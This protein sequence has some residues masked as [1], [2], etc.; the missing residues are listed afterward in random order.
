MKHK[1]LV[2]LDVT[3]REKTLKDAKQELMR[4]RSQ[5]AM[6]GQVKNTAQ[7]RELRKTIARIK[8]LEKQN[9]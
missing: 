2:A 1:K 9:G 3:G 5:V 4:L 8:T 6:G 7:L